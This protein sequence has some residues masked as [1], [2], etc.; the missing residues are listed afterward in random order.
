MAVSEPYSALFEAAAAALVDAD[1]PF[2]AARSVQY[3]LGQALDDL[4]PDE[5]LAA[6]LTKAKTMGPQALL[7]W[8]S[9][10]PGD[11]RAAGGRSLLETV[12][13]AVRIACGAPGVAALGYFAALTADGAARWWGL[14]PVRRWVIRRMSTLAIAGFVSVPVYR[15][16]RGVALGGG[17]GVAA[18]ALYFE[19]QNIE[20]F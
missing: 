7:S 4:A 14:F 16:C 2:V 18:E 20:D 17:D 9:D 19:V 15:G 3:W 10:A 5:R 6:A 8:E 12:V 1:G 11:A 13:F